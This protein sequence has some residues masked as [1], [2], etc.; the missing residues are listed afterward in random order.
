MW[1]K[2]SIQSVGKHISIDIFLTNYNFHKTLG[3]VSLL[4][5]NKSTVRKL[6]QLQNNPLTIFKNYFSRAKIKIVI[7]QEKVRTLSRVSKVRAFYT[8]FMIGCEIVH[9]NLNEILL[10]CHG[11][12]WS[13]S[14]LGGQIRRK[15][16]FFGIIF[17]SSL[18]KA[19]PDKIKIINQKTWTIS[20]LSFQSTT[21]WALHTGQA[22]LNNF[23]SLRSKIYRF[24]DSQ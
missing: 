19:F 20:G 17:T 1:R 21:L 13:T 24:R 12:Y 14:A 15:P 23:F 3:K 6:K 10:F 11:I 18:E 5:K 9:G 7:W 16:F 22:A 2:Y 8:Y 4:R